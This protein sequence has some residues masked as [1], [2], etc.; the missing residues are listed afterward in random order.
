MI[1]RAGA[2]LAGGRE[3]ARSF[4]AL[5]RPVNAALA[6]SVW[7]RARLSLGNRQW[8]VDSLG[9]APRQAF[10]R[11]AG[12]HVDA[13]GPDCSCARVAHIELG[14]TRRATTAALARGLRRRGTVS[15]RIELCRD[16]SARPAGT[17]RSRGAERSLIRGAELLEAHRAALGALELRAAA[18]GMG[19]ELFDSG[20]GLRSPPVGRLGS[21]IGP[22]GS[23]E[24][25]C[26]FRRCDRPPT[27]LRRLQAELRHVSAEIR[28]AEAKGTP[29]RGSGGEAGRDRGE[30]PG[31]RP[32]V[33]G[34]G[35][36]AD[37]A[38]RR[39]GGR[40]R[41]RKTCARRVRRSPTGGSSPSR[42]RTDDRRCRASARRRG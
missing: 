25:P 37:R 17:R 2:R 23:A 38:C 6:R 10:S 30:D 20:S 39:G 4:A 31:A 12:W 13:L 28:E 27:R 40:S 11:S 1:G 36:R 15:D 42:S 9:A 8:F 41:A 7:L 32:A 19:G 5:G 18:S 22:N 16:G 29:A 34:A 14:A 33:R 3:A 21:S 26:G 24:T 35:E